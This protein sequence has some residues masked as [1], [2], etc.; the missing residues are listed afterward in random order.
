MASPSPRNSS[1]K[2]H[3]PA[4]EV[5]DL[6]SPLV[7]TEDHEDSPSAE[8]LSRKAKTFSFGGAKHSRRKRRNID[9]AKKW[10]RSYDPFREGRVM[11]VDCF[12]RLHSDNERRRT[13]SREF[14]TQTELEKFYTLNNA[15]KDH[16]PCLRI[17]HVQNAVWARELMFKKYCIIE[18]KMESS[19]NAFSRWAK[20]DK[21]Q[22]RN[23]HPVLNSKAFSLDK[24]IYRKVWR[25]GYGTDYLRYFAPGHMHC[26]MEPNLSDFK[27]FQLDEWKETEETSYCAPGPDVYV[28]RLSLYIQRNMEGAGL[29]DDE[30]DDSSSDIDKEDQN[31]Q[32][33]REN[34]RA[35]NT[36]TVIV[37]ESSHSGLVK[38]TLIE[39]RSETERRWVSFFFWL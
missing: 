11:I 7:A 23:G 16:S 19:Q 20:Y 12:S 36:T 10:S 4:I 35:D 32:T 13:I 27:I 37:F 17:I 28:Q 14:T 39:A 5:E 8:G 15:D 31:P 30:W 25:C 33:Q 22:R 1:D 18:G 9:W 3:T 21:P 6:T 26:S 2:S 34:K 24:N 38:D 29:E